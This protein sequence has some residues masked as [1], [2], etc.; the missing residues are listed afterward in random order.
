[1]GQ[2]FKHDSTEGSGLAS[3]DF[4]GGIINVAGVATTNWAFD[5]RFR[6]VST[7]GN[8][9]LANVSFTFVAGFVGPVSILYLIA[10]LVRI[11]THDSNPVACFAPHGYGS[12][13]VGLTQRETALLSL[14]DSGDL[15]DRL[16][17]ARALYKIQQGDLDNCK[18]AYGVNVHS[19]L[20]SL[21]C[22]IVV[23]GKDEYKHDD[24]SVVVPTYFTS[25]FARK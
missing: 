12:G 4:S 17:A 18:R 6:V 5:L 20:Q 10:N 11:P 25:L 8:N 22:D 2:F 19:V 21:I 3:I 24:D 15:A 13:Q 1:V 23:S 16:V 7:S 14:F 9:M